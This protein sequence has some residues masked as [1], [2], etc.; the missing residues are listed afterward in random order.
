MDTGVADLATDS[1]QLLAVKGVAA[2]AGCYREL[3]FEFTAGVLTLRCHDDTDEVVAEVGRPGGHAEP[4][5]DPWAQALLGKW[6]EYAWSLRN[7]R[8][9]NDGFQ[10]RLMNDE[11]EAELRQ[12]EVA[13][14]VIEVRIVLPGNAVA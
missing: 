5:E 7:H 6:I 11:R 2:A 1:G 4:I 12:F 8:G 3:E 14:S 13:G 9:Y 10:L